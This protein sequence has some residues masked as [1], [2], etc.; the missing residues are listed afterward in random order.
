MHWEPAVTMALHNTAL[1]IVPLMSS[2]FVSYGFVLT[3]EDI[4]SSAHKHSPEVT[5]P[6]GKVQGTKMVTHHGRTIIG[7]RGIPFAQPPIGALRFAI[8]NVAK[9]SYI[10]NL[11]LINIAVRDETRARKCEIY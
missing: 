9:F 4:N 2:F 8:R 3:K 6:Q 10:E 11:K 7:F 5:I 1:L